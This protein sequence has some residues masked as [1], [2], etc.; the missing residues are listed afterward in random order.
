MSEFP[1]WCQC[2]IVTEVH[3]EEGNK[4]WTDTIRFCEVHEKV[5]DTIG[6]TD[7]FAEWLRKYPTVSNQSL[8]E[9]RKMIKAALKSYEKF[10][11]DAM[12]ALPAIPR[13]VTPNG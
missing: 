9:W 2:Q 7:D 4:Y 6:W 13:K 5:L 11:Y 12:P 3:E 10:R 8:R 1:T